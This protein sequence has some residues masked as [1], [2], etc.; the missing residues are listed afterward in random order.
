MHLSEKQQLI[1]KLIFSENSTLLND[2]YFPIMNI[3][4]SYN[5]FCVSRRIMV[6]TI[7]DPSYPSSYVNDSVQGT[8]I[9]SWCRSIFIIGVHA[10][11][12]F[13]L[14]DNDGIAIKIHRLTDPSAG[15]R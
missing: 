7:S 13:A 15:T 10:Y 1:I 3:A 9:A 6:D 12:R 5:R 4:A 11:K 8:E 2:A 14:N